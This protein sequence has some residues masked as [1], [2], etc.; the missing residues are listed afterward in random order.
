M[1]GK[2]P[3]PQGGWDGAM[4]PHQTPSPMGPPGTGVTQGGFMGCLR[5]AVQVVL[6]R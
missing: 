3:C 2:D 4:A 6:S 1:A 5:G